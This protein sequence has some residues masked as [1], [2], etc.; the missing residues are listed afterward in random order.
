MVG[1]I[2]SVRQTAWRV[3]FWGTNAWRAEVVTTRRL[4]GKAPARF[5]YQ[6][7]AFTGDCVSPDPRP[8]SGQVLV[9]PLRKVDARYIGEDGQSHEKPNWKGHYA[10]YYA[11]P[12]PL[13]RKHYGDI[14]PSP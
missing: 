13:W 11:M 8:R 12:E 9:F 7:T 4:H 6:A 1:K 14:Y 10:S 2:I 3:L 5:S